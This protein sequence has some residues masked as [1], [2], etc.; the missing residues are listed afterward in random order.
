MKTIELKD[1]RRYAVEFRHAR[2]DDRKAALGRRSPIRAITTCCVVKVRSERED[3]DPKDEPWLVDLETPGVHSPIWIS[4]DSA[5]C[6][7]GDNFSRR[8]GRE[9]AMRKVLGRMKEFHE[10]VSVVEEFWLAYW[11]KEAA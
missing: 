8:Y 4:M 7:I 9:L 1:G 10:P 6:E 2:S 11:G 5:V 3:D